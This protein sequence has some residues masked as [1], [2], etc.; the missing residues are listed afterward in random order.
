MVKE[1]DSP[2][3]ALGQRVVMDLMR[4]FLDKGHKLSVDN[5]YISVPLFV[6]LGTYATGT[7]VANCKHF[8]KGL[9]AERNQLATGS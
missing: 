3:V 4:P 6:D 8:P 1:V 7:I 5:F 2:T 9:K